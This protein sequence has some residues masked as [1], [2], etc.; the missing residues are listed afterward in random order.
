VAQRG[1]NRGGLARTRGGTLGLYDAAR[2]PS[3][4]PGA[5]VAHFTAIS[6][7]TLSPARANSR[8]SRR[9]VRGRGHAAIIVPV[10][11][12]A[13]MSMLGS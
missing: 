6:T 10:S 5:P 4:G 7:L 9:D 1:C 3:R 12:V 8:A 11:V 13:V 2:L